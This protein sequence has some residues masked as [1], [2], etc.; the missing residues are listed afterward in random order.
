MYMSVKFILSKMLKSSVSLLSL[1]LD[2]LRID[3]NGVLMSPNFILLPSVSLFRSVN[4][5]FIYLGSPMLGA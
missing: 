3:E 1:C 2:V 4:T 5:C